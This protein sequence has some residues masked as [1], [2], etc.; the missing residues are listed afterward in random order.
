[1]DVPDGADSVS[2]TR[3]T[4]R[5][6]GGAMGRRGGATRKT[7]R[8]ERSA[9]RSRGKRSEL[10]PRELF[11]RGRRATKGRTMERRGKHR[12]F[13]CGRG[14][15]FRGRQSRPG[16]SEPRR[17]PR[18]GGYV[19]LCPVC[20]SVPRGVNRVAPPGAAI[21]VDGKKAASTRAAAPPMATN[22]RKAVWFLIH[23]G[24]RK[25]GSFLKLT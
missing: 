10:D 18:A 12:V 23:P 25:S 7:I 8:P 15:G 2:V 14:W 5:S 20:L 16:F 24:T 11:G 22:P 19:S 4:E 6:C 9:V 17:L 3:A 21:A 13:S 1:M